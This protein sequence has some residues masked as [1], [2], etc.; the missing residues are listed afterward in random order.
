MEAFTGTLVS[1]SEGRY[2]AL[3]VYAGYPTE[4]VSNLKWLFIDIFAVKIF[5][6]T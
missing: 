4:H 6:S 5:I 3:C 2:T 1:P